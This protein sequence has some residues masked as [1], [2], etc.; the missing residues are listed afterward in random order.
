MFVDAEV[1][2]NFVIAA[3]NVEVK[4]VNILCP[5]WVAINTFTHT[6]SL[7][8][9]G[10]GFGFTCAQSFVKEASENHKPSLGQSF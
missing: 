9:A 6:S 10:V 4:F 8:G 5:L 2:Y 1:M 7:T 3:R